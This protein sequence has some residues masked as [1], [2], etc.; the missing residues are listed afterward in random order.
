ML[1]TSHPPTYYLPPTDVRM[2]HL[3]VTEGR[4]FCEWKGRAIYYDARLDGR[5]VRRVAWSYPDPTRTFEPLRD[6][7]AFYLPALDAGLVDDEEARPQPG[8]FYGGWITSDLA[9]PF[10]GEPGSAGW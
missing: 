3:T 7:L 1:E 4:S 2:G 10:K 6:H 8:S 9:G 5:V